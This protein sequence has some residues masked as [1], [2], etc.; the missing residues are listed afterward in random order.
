MFGWNPVGMGIKALIV[1]GIVISITI[2]GIYIRNVIADNA[3]QKQEISNLKEQR[4][5]LD[6]SI[7]ASNAA[8]EKWQKKYA[9]LKTENGRNYAILDQNLARDS[10]ANNC[11]LSADVLHGLD[12]II[13]S[14]SR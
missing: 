4:K 1:L 9:D 10:A 8:S 13:D 7:A 6:H 14:A 12:A 11:V 5:Q 2:A 3:L